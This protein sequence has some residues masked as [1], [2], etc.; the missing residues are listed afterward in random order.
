[1]DLSEESEP[2]KGLVKGFFLWE[3]GTKPV[4]LGWLSSADLFT[5]D[6][7][8][9]L[10]VVQ[11]EGAQGRS[12]RRITLSDQ[13]SVLLAT[14]PDPYAFGQ[15]HV[16]DDLLAFSTRETLEV[17][18]LAGLAA[19]KPLVK[20]P[21]AEAQWPRLSPDGRHL[22]WEDSPRK[23]GVPQPALRVTPASG[24]EPLDLGALA[25]SARIEFEWFDD[26]R[27]LVCDGQGVRLVALDGA[28][29]PLAGPG[30]CFV[31]RGAR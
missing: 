16:V 5:P 6:G 24:G 1:D 9:V 8:S 22:A 29:E 4:H 23:N 10:Q 2:V 28:S 26:T 31:P 15:L 11:N 3:R 18:P 20:R 25:G 21:F 12:L 19:A 30:T 14:R 7:Q 13:A 17:A 27:F